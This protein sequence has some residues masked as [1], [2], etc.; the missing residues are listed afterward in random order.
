MG[1]CCSRQSEDEVERL[2]METLPKVTIDPNHVGKDCVVVKDDLRVCGT[3]GALGN[4]PLVQDK[5]YWE[6]KVQTEGIWGVG[7]ALATEDLNKVP[8]GQS[9]KSW[10]FRNDGYIYHNGESYAQYGDAAK[11]NEGDVIG[12]SYDHVDLFFYINGKRL[13][14]SAMTVRGQVYPVVYVDGSAILDLRFLRF[15]NPPPRGYDQIMFEQSL[16]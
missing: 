14:C 9:T 1:L 13:D 12:C 4:A 5:S 15:W 6:I 10:V 3:G 11:V 8:L 2:R 16:L 7:V